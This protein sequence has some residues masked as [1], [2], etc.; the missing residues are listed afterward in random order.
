MKREFIS[1]AKSF[2]RPAWLALKKANINRMI[3]QRYSSRRYISPENFDIDLFK[4]N[5]REFLRHVCVDN[6]FYLYKYSGSAQQATLYSSAY[7]CMT[8]SLLGDLK[9]L[10][11]EQRAKWC[12]YF[13]SFQS[14]DD[15]LFYDETVRN[16]IYDTSDWWGARHLALHM[17]N[18]YI[19]LG[20]R[21]S[22]PFSFLR[23]YYDVG[24]IESWLDSYDWS[25]SG[26]GD[27]DIDNKIMNIGCLLQYQR[28]HWGDEGASGAI[29][30]L[31][32]YLK[33]KINPKTGIWGEGDLKCLA[34]RS[35]MIQFAY[36]LFP[37]YLYDGEFDFEAAKIVRI[38]LG[39]Q[40][41]LG[42]YGVSLNSSACEDIDSIDILLRFRSACD[43]AL[44]AE[45]DE[46]IHRAYKWVLINQVGDGGFVFRLFEPFEY[47]SHALYSAS[48]EG[49]MLPLWFRTLS[50]AYI[51]RH[52]GF[53]QHFLLNKSPGYEFI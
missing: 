4:T 23:S 34:Y 22:Y 11:L 24:A 31:K 29:A 9:S 37:I 8:L 47:G 2:L 26:L 10:S 53:D 6:N 14:A 35:R 36:H 30:R 18:A 21:P 25:G 39:T 5:I 40:N 44:K 17:A 33:S 50:L 15:G 19:D 38:A 41:A 13:D 52:Y 27:S 32:C 48:N 12:S 43:A 20:G 49:G 51:F 3:S 42:G 7:A 46:S 45:I 28:D 16:E 1:L